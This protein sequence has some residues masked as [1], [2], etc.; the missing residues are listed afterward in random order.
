[1]KKL[2][3]EVLTELE[4][5]TVSTVANMWGRAEDIPC[6]LLIT[7][8]EVQEILNE[9]SHHEEYFLSKFNSSHDYLI[10][11]IDYCK[12]GFGFARSVFCHASKFEFK[13]EFEKACKENNM[14]FIECARTDR[15]YSA[16]KIMLLDLITE[17]ELTLIKDAL[18]DYLLEQFEAV[19]RL[20]AWQAYDKKIKE[21]KEQRIRELF[22]CSASLDKDPYGSDGTYGM[23]DYV[24]KTNKPVN[25][26]TIIEIIK[27][28]K[29][30]KA[31]ELP[32]WEQGYTKPFNRIATYHN[33]WG[34]ETRGVSSTWYW[35]H[36]VGTC[37]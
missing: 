36:N 29:G 20:R 21:E 34:D 24:I 3:K 9:Y 6:S 31:L 27:I 1:M 16:T 8:Q 26:D 2:F 14:F 12:N 32:E 15:G 7:N 18:K 22:D 28:L 30:E 25:Y 33:A 17:K 23:Y 19:A 5:T 10:S 11:T 13:N 35:H 37:D 4:N